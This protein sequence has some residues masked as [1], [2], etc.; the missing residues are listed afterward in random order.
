MR[1]CGNGLQIAWIRVEGHLAKRWPE[2][3]KGLNQVLFLSC[4]SPLREAL[5]IQLN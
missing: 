2:L 5:A 3:F 4:L 1:Y